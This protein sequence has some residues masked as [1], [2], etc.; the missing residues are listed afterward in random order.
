MALVLSVTSATSVVGV[1][2][3]NWSGDVDWESAAGSGAAFAYVQATEGANYVNPR[4]AAQFNGAGAAGLIRGAYHFAQPHESTGAKQADYFVAHGGRWTNDGTT[5]PGVLDLEDNP[6]KAKNGKDSCYGLTQDEEVA[7]I[8]DFTRRYRARTGRDAIIYTTTSW[9]Q[10]CTGDSKAFGHNPLWLASWAAKPGTLPA[11]WKRYTFWQSTDKGPIVGGQN[12]FN[13]TASQLRALASP[14]GK[15]V[16]AAKVAGRTKYTLLVGN[17]GKNPLTK[18]KVTGK[19]FGGL[20]FAKVGR[21]C[22]ASGTAV[23]CTIPTLKAGTYV[24]LKFLARP[25]GHGPYGIRFAAPG[26]KVTVKAR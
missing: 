17:S 4:F 10:T 12:A 25:T 5:L 22:K 2:V 13:G 7:W 9:W 26:A 8:T 1:D 23:V 18:V 14:P 3:S 6:Y 20:K 21:Y 16:F 24:T 11:S 15:V 19:S